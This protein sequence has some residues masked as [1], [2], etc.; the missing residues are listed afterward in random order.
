MVKGKVTFKDGTV[1]KVQATNFISLFNA[2][3]GKPIRKIE[4]KEIELKEMRQGRDG[5]MVG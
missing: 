3:V 1:E 5:K 4:V 2:L